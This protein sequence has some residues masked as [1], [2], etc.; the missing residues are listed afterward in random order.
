VEAHQ[1]R[2]LVL[3]VPSE[4]AVAGLKPDLAAIAGWPDV[5]GVIVTARGKSADFVSRFFAPAGGIPE[6]PVT[7][8]AHATL[9][10]FWASRLGKSNTTMTVRQLSPR[11]GELRCR[12]AGD[13]V[14]I[15]GR[16]RLYMEGRI[17]FHAIC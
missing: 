4:E 10:P 3:V 9:T 16:A 1:A 17:V 2:D 14:K 7:G 8:S 6:D 11:G 13:R 15:A 12:D 5:F